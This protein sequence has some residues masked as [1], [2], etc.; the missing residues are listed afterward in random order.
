VLVRSVAVVGG[1][2]DFVRHCC[3]VLLLGVRSGPDGR[4]GRM[5]GT[6]LHKAASPCMM[7]RNLAKLLL[8]LDNR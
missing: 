3:L 8:S 4:W 2:V 1:K 7:A 5:T 6:G